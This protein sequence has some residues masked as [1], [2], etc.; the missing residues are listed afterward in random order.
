MGDTVDCYQRILRI[1][2]ILIDPFASYPNLRQ[3]ERTAL[4]MGAFGKTNAEI[5]SEIG[6]S[7]LS[8]GTVVSRALAKVGLSKTELPG[9][10]LR[11]IEK[12]V[13]EDV[14]AGE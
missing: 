14:E 1:R 8:A 4:R 13:N 12:V 7:P 3:V 2:A 10:V 11:R 6:Y 9:H 5:A